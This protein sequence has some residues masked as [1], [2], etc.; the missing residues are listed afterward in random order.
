MKG[1]MVEYGTSGR[2]SMLVDYRR[3]KCRDCFD[4]RVSEDQCVYLRLGS[5]KSA[6][7][8]TG[9]YSIQLISR[10]DAHLPHM[11]GDEP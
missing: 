5:G 1:Y 8:E 9:D 2:D 6:F 7:F 3:G 11:C 4:L 10:Y